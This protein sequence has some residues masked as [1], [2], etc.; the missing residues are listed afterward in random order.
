METKVYDRRLKEIVIEKQFKK[1]Y[2]DFLYKTIIGRILLKLFFS[3][4]G[5]SKL[6]SVYIDSKKSVKKIEPF[7]E[8]YSIDMSDYK[9]KNYNSFNDFFVREIELHKRPYS[10]DKNTLISV[11]DAKLMAYKINNEL[12]MNIKN[13]TY[14]ISEL[15]KDHTLGKGY[16]NG[17]CLV[18]RLTVDDYHRYHFIDDGCVIQQKIINGV[19]HTV[20]PISSER[21]NVYIENHR[22]VSVLK[23][24]NLGEFIQIEVGAILVGKI[25]NHK[26]TT[27]R[28][29]DEK[30]YFS[31]GGS[32]VLLLFKEG[33]MKVDSDILEFSKEG[34]ETKVRM[35]EKIGGIIK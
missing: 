8:K 26:V 31:F 6:Y 28:R 20:G 10:S 19:L 9:Y 21:H 16:H 34:I 14:T 3:K 22:E 30:G 27:F 17:T 33:S 2:L 13:S 25:T 5:F 7:I 12:N 11:A 4:K 24:E 35:G 1:S 18:F 32:T 23:S 15:L 29:G